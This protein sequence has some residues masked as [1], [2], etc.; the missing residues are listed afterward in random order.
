MTV[1]AS[2]T[3]SAVLP[4]PRG[5]LSE[6]VVS[7]LGAP[8]SRPVALPARD[9]VDADPFGDDLALALHTCY[10]L[11]YR[12]FAGVMPDWEWDADLLR[13]RKGLEDRFRQALR[14]GVAGGDDVDGE[15]AGLLIE[16]VP[17]DGPSHH[18]RDRGSWGQLQEYFVHRS[19][20]HLK[21]ADPHAWVIP[22]LQGQAKA[23]LVAVEFDEFGGGR[24]EDVHAQLFADLLGAAG[25]EPGYLHYLDVVPAPQLAIV[26]LMSMFGLHRALRGALVGHFAAAE[27]STAPSARRLV[28][29]LDRFDAPEACT[30]FFTEH[31]EADA[32]HE[33]IMRH[34]VVGDLLARE[35]ELA[36]DVV[37]GVQATEL[38]EG[39][40]AERLL[41]AWRAGRSSLLHPLEAA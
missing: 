5:P 14:D 40:L 8:P 1:P 7:A 22:R 32:V 6:A 2:T 27:I 20:Y 36:A 15:L 11:H 10:E 13:W 25:L 28:S 38:L 31:V 12:G 26:N 4:R 19:I 18:L 37:F 3:T 41:G 23:A 35:P 29:A 39:A 24:G 30:R 21:E 34:D 17:G 9:A 33:Q 16:P